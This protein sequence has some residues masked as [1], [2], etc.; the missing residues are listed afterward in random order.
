MWHYKKPWLFFFLVRK[1]MIVRKQI[2]Q[3]SSNTQIYFMARSSSFK[4][5]FEKWLKDSIFLKERK[6]LIPFT[7]IKKVWRNYG[8][9][10]I[11]FQKHNI[12]QN[13]VMV[14]YHD[15]TNFSNNLNIV[16]FLFFSWFLISQWNNHIHV[17]NIDIWSLIQ[18]DVRN[19][20]SILF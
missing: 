12:C 2:S 6:K 19:H 3:P 4:I 8:M 13:H 18:H 9:V 15:F 16:I 10:L 20:I 5:G 1:T 17:T 14:T 11:K 7:F